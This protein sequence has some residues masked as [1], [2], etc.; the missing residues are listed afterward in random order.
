MSVDGTKLL[1]E[2]FLQ[3]RKDTMKLRW[4]TY[5]FRLQNA[6]LFFYTQKNG[7][8]SHLKGYYYIFTVQSV[9]EVQRVDSKRFVFEIIMKNGK[10]KVL[11]ADTAVLRKE[12]VGHLWQAMHLSTSVVSD[13]RSTHVDVCEQR[14]R[15]N[16]SAPIFSHSVMESL[17]ARPLSAPSHIQHEIRSIAPSEE[18]DREETLYQNTLP[19]CSYQHHNGSQWTSGWSN[20]VEGDYDILPLRNKVC[21]VNASTDMD[22]DVYDFPVSYRRAAEQPNPTES[23]YDV[24]SAL[25]RRMPDRP[26]EDQPEDGD[27]WRI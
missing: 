19:D 21:E 22:E 10:R 14:E 20:A 25:L 5:W 6:T 24:P 26:S 2:G 9:R 13:S 3:K 23:I 15:V 12:W 4:M 1:F 11:A 16:S 7:S 8:A 17:P 18:P 27:Y